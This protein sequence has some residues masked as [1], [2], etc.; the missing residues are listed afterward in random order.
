[1]KRSVSE[2]Q[3]AELVAYV[4]LDVS[5]EDYL[6]SLEEDV[7]DTAMHLWPSFEVFEK[8][9]SGGHKVLLRNSFCQLGVSTGDGVAAI[10]VRPCGNRFGIEYPILSASYING[11]SR[12]F[13]EYF[14]HL[15][16]KGRVQNN[17]T[18]FERSHRMSCEA[19]RD[20]QGY[21]G[22]PEDVKDHSQGK[23]EPHGRKEDT[24]SDQQNDSQGDNGA[25]D[26][27][28]FVYWAEEKGGR[29]LPYLFKSLSRAIEE[30]VTTAHL[31][32]FLVRSVETLNPATGRVEVTAVKPSDNEQTLVY[33]IDGYPLIPARNNRDI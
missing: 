27:T 10:W 5:Y 19:P 9:I 12:R 2:P 17:V 16:P 32:G 4:P 24:M 30:T 13:H 11:I 1:M 25:R 20:P 23:F 33:V 6:L 31:R 26:D 7:Q 21:A 15:V 22:S 14:G 8:Y 18:F 28:L 3:D 29:K